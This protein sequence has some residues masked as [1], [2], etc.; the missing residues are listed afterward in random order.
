[1]GGV[2]ASKGVPYG[3]PTGG[4]D[5]VMRPKKAKPW[6]GAHDTVERRRDTG[7]YRTGRRVVAGGGVAGGGVAGAGRATRTASVIPQPGQ[8]S[9][10][11]L[12]RRPRGSQGASAERP[13]RVCPRRVSRVEQAQV[14]G[15]LAHHA[16]VLHRGDEPQLG[17]TVRVCEHADPESAAH[18]RPSGS[19]TTT[20][21]QAMPV[22]MVTVPK[23]RRRYLTPRRPT[24]SMSAQSPGG[25]RKRS[26]DCG[27]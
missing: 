8:S 14:H 5:R 4:A 27:R 20:P 19:E 17:A 11:M 18:Q 1:M 10:A 15:N 9:A 26:T 3:A 7:H 6:A 13:R 23:P 21:S 12:R 16:R 22:W 24:A 2:D 25:V